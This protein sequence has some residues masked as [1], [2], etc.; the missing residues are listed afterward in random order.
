M[1][2]PLLAICL[3]SGLVLPASAQADPE[4]AAVLAV[5]ARLFDGMRRHDSGMVRSVFAAE[6][7]L[8]GVSMRTGTPVVQV[9]SVDDFVKAVGSATGDPWDE[10]TYDPEVRIDDRLATVWA[11]YDFLLGPRWSHCGV[12]A[13][14]L[15]KLADGWK[16][17]QIAD[18]RQRERCT[19]P[20]APK[21]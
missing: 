11:R 13:F 16:I 3:L 6:S 18:T 14:M 10:R 7:R 2:C 20:A 1:R 17:T 4:P 8:L 9:T 21:S 19:T 15:A 5:V 12:D